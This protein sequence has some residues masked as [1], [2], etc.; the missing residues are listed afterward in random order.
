[1]TS[2]TSYCLGLRE[3]LLRGFQ[4]VCESHRRR[5]THLRTSPSYGRNSGTDPVL[6]CAQIAQTARYLSVQPYRPHWQMI[7]WL[8]RI[9]VS[10]SRAASGFEVWTDGRMTIQIASAARPCPRQL[11]IISPS[12]WGDQLWSWSCLLTC[13]RR[14]AKG[15]DGQRVR[16]EHGGCGHGRQHRPHLRL[17]LQ[18]TRSCTGHVFRVTSAGDEDGPEP[19]SEPDIMT[20]KEA[21]ATSTVPANPHTYSVPSSELGWSRVVIW[22][23]GAPP[24]VEPPQLAKAG[25]QES[26]AVFFAKSQSQNESS[27]PADFSMPMDPGG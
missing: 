27:P 7:D 23:R 15:G 26:K 17:G 20:K 9:A 5:F 24:Q 22:G 19:Q 3:S 11:C 1:M 18:R 13:A 14:A 10:S 4:G 6:A 12:K 25:C 2:A 21:S 16:K 8:D